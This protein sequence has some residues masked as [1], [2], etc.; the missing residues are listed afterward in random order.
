QSVVPCWDIGIADSYISFS[1][2]SCGFVGASAPDL[3]KRREFLSHMTSFEVRPAVVDGDLFAFERHLG[4]SRR[5]GTLTLILRRLLLSLW[6]RLR[7]WLLGDGCKR[8]CDDR[9]CNQISTAHVFSSLSD[10]MEEAFA[11]VTGGLMVPGR[12]LSTCP[13]GA[14]RDVLEC[15]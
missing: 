2:K 10:Y 12:R 6:L 9:E 14:A 3:A 1:N 4:G 11:L 5:A 13:K 15:H 8:E 7:L